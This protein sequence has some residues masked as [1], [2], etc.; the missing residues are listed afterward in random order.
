[1]S[2]GLGCISPVNIMVEEQYRERD[3]QQRNKQKN[4]ISIITRKSDCVLTIR[5]NPQRKKTA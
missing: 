4:A 2:I 1:M 3:Q 5:Q